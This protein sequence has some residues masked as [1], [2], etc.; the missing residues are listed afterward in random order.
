MFVQICWRCSAGIMLVDVWD[1][2]YQWWSRR[3]GHGNDQTSWI[4]EAHQYS[5]FDPPGIQLMLSKEV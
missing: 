5:H 3:K 4:C 2:V 1:G